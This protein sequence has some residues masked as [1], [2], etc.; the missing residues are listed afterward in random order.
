MQCK[1]IMESLSHHLLA[2]EER[3]HQ[4]SVRTDPQSLERLLADGFREFGSSGTTY[5]RRET[6][7]A[8]A[9]AAP[10]ART[11]RDFTMVLASPRVALVTYRTQSHES[12]TLR[13]SLWIDGDDG[14][15]MLFHQGT[16]VPDEPGSNAVS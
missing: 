15:Q 6:I 8:L 13:S 9:E 5:T 16:R 7:D 12:E 3:L 10:Q 11:M 1:N 14:W 4:T 2:L